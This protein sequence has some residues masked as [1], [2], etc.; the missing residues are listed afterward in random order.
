ST[1]PRSLK[2][3]ETG[4]FPVRRDPI[5]VAVDSLSGRGRRTHDSLPETILRGTWPARRSPHPRLESEHQRPGGL[6]QRRCDGSDSLPDHDLMSITA[7]QLQSVYKTKGE[8]DDRC[9]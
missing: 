6:S 5:R 9:R 7:A 8:T 2:R 4:S 3:T 1:T